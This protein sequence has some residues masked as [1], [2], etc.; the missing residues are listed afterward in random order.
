MSLPGWKVMRAPGAALLL[1]CLPLAGG[2]A[3]A[4]GAGQGSDASVSDAPALDAPL[5][6]GAP[7]SSPT[8]P[9]LW[10]QRAGDAFAY[11]D[12]TWWKEGDWERAGGWQR[13]V[14]ADMLIAYR[15]RTG[16]TRFD[17]RIHTALR[18]HSR[19]ALN[20]DALWAVI[21]SV[22]G[23][24]LEGD[25]QLLDYA[26]TTFTGLVETYWDETCGGGIWWG[27][28][29]TYK[30]AITNELLITA[31]TRL[32]RVTGQDSYRQWALRG[33]GWLGASGMIGGDGLVNDGLAIDAKTGVCTNN[34]RPQW[35]YN[36]G[37]ILS[38][39]SDLTRITGEPIYRQRAVAMA[40]TALA[41]LTNP[42]GTL[43][44]PV[45]AIG[46][47]GLAFKGIFAFHLAA[48]MDDLPEGPDKEALR[49]AARRN[50]EAIWRI[51][52]GAR[53]PID[54]DWTGQTH[55]YG[56]GAQASGAAML[57]AADR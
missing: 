15:K 2:T 8:A 39:L 48:L 23:Y 57:L 45:P 55:Q 34:A 49:A 46:L 31:A 3:L 26:A 14:L 22:D 44:E 43:R 4:Q 27:P 20:D 25:P 36:Q 47:D 53:E 38:G 7:D 30:N 54:S 12:A 17:D 1:A 29:R 28:H 52:A 32:Y 24:E 41:T 9:G 42:D 56:G 50:A 5:A 33:W 16:D 51:S 35:T 40:R 37:V 11:L 10:A 13:F 19:L 21:A 18:N 6:D